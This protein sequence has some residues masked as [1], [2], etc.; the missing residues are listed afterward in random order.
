M[1]LRYSSARQVDE[2]TSTHEEAE[3][4]NFE[5]SFEQFEGLGLSP[6]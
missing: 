6:F 4:N 3:G 5:E 2:L 1:M